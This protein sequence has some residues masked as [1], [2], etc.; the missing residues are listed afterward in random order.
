MT[1]L[2]HFVLL[3]KEIMYSSRQKLAVTSDLLM[4]VYLSYMHLTLAA[5]NQ[6]T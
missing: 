2:L 6:I 5:S 3:K 4:N 1:K